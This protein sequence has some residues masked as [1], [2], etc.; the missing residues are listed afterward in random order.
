MKTM[1]NLKMS[2]EPQIPNPLYQY[3][4]CTKDQQ[5]VHKDE[6][7]NC[8]DED[9]EYSDEYSARSQDSGRTVFHPDLYVLT[10]DEHWTH[11]YAAAVGSFCFVTAE[12]GEQQDVCNLIT[13][14]SVQRSL[15]LNEVT[16]G[17]SSSKVEVPKGVEPETCWNAVWSPA[18]KQQEQE[19]ERDVVHERKHQL[20]KYEGT[21]N[22]SLKQNVLRTC[23]GLIMKFLISLTGGRL[24]RKI[25]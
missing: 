13:I 5:Q 17:S 10:N 9:S 2:L 20:G 11:K 16:N 23:L 12:N 4:H 14:P 18:E 24:N 21:T 19:P 3:Y 7:D 25:M 22:S 6:F 1:K 15:Y 8:V